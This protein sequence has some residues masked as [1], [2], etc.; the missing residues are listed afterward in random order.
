[1]NIMGKKRRKRSI[2]HKNNGSETYVTHVV[3]DVEPGYDWTFRD[4]YKGLF[5]F[6]YLLI[7]L[8]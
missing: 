7:Y 5:L 3:N 8:V 2:Y 1:M 6:L 4:I